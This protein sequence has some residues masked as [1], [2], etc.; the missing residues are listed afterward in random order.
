MIAIVKTAP[1]R[2]P[3]TLAEA[4]THL[5]LSSET[6]NDDYISG[7]LSASVDVAEKFT[8]RKLG[9]SNCHTLHGLLAEF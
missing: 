6:G 5:R 7:L 3:V 4:K 2:L 1:A 8:G 9:L